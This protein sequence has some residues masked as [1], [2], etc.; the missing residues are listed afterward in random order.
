M[1]GEVIAALIALGG[2]VV[3]GF[4]K[5]FWETATWVGSVNSDRKH[6]REVADR[7]DANFAELLLRIPPVPVSGESPLR[8]TDLGKTLS[9]KLN[10]KAWAR[11]TAPA[12]VGRLKGKTA[13]EI[14]EHCFDH[15]RS[16]QFEENP[17]LARAILDCAFE[18]GLRDSQVRE[19]LGVELRDM[20]FGCMDLKLPENPSNSAE[21]A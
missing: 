19:V 20:V 9:N 4:L 3:Y 7:V 6:F 8:L 16:H 21:N 12:M 17:T 5:T 18:H 2:A 1:D 15:A 13:Y 11:Q 10:A 14:Q